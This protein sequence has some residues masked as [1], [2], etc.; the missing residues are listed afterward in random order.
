VGLL[1]DDS[2]EPPPERIS[3]TLEGLREDA[4]PDVRQGAAALLKRIERV[5][6]EADG[7]RAGE[8]ATP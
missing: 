1:V 8:A 2:G 6:R 5:V 3:A 7:S 4:I